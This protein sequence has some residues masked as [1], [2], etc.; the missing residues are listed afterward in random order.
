M[1]LNYQSEVMYQQQLM[2]EANLSMLLDQYCMS[3]H[4]NQYSS[5]IDI[6]TYQ[7]ASKDISYE[8]SSDKL[9]NTD[10]KLIK[11]R[12]RRNFLPNLD[13]DLMKILQQ[14]RNG[15]LKDL[16]SE[17]KL[18]KSQINKSSRRSSQFIGV[19]KNG[20]NW[21]S[22][23]NHGHS[24][25]YIGTYSTEIEAAIAYDFFAIALQGSK[26]R[27]N[28]RYNCEILVEMINSYYEDERTFIPNKF[29]PK[30][31]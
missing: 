21:Q 22:L 27:L 14:A 25:K 31:L 18:M 11:K 15:D 4:E 23:I 12:K 6:S 20:D 7:S 3:S 29:I 2:F 9:K 30:L 5:A 19:S 10:D 8:V 26:S 1:Q 17:K 16:F 13:S 28:F 24:K